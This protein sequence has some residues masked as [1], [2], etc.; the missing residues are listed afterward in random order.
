MDETRQTQTNSGWKKP[1]SY[2]LVEHF[3]VS[4]L[5]KHHPNLS[6]MDLVDLRREAKKKKKDL[7][8]FH[9]NLN[10]QTDGVAIGLTLGSLLANVFMTS[11]EEILL[12]EGIMSSSYNYMSHDTLTI[13]LDITSAAN[14]LQ[15]LNKC[16]SSVNFTMELQ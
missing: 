10:E 5:I 12:R 4:G 8:Q 14:F 1:C 13:M 9:G 3:F 7:F 11:I 16:H 6:I 2:S 15:V